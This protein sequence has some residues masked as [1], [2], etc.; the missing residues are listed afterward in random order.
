MQI[1]ALTRISGLSSQIALS[2]ICSF[3]DNQYPRQ[4]QL[5]QHW[6]QLDIKQFLQSQIYIRFKYPIDVSE[7]QIQTND[8][9]RNHQFASWRCTSTGPLWS[10]RFAADAFANSDICDTGGF[11]QTDSHQCLWFSERF[12]KQDFDALQIP[13]DDD[14]QKIISALELL[15]QIAIVLQ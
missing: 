5:G 7:I 12:T 10:G 9:W 13:I 11:I 3:D 4:S 2:M 1:T 14:L 6:C 8:S 15:A